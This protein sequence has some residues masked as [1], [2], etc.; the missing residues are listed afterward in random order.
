VHNVRQEGALRFALIMALEDRG[1][2]PGELRVEVIEPFVEGRLDL[3]VGDP[4]RAVVQL[5]FPRDFR[6]GISRTR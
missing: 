5:K 2:S 1:A 4:I 6:T 3:V